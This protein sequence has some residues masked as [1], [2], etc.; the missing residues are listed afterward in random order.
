MD[1]NKSTAKYWN[2]LAPLYDA[3][4]GDGAWI[5]NSVL[6]EELL[7]SAVRASTALDLG[8]GT[9]QTLSQICELY[10]DLQTLVAVDISPAMIDIAAAKFPSAETHAEDLVQFLARD[11]RLFD[12]VVAIG[13][14][15]FIPDLP[16]VLLQVGKHLNSKGSLI[17]TYEPLI[18]GFDPQTSHMET[19]VSTAVSDTSFVTY[20]WTP[21]EILASVLSWGN[22]CSD[23]LFVS[24]HR[25]EKPVIYSLFA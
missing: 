24:Y 4:T 9:G 3:A 8:C 17:F 15:E 16:Q 5:P 7:A 18:P 10:P 12:L 19:S 23:R 6:G 2:G 13:S 25:A 1:L 14:L 21:A 22:L 20:R 11:A